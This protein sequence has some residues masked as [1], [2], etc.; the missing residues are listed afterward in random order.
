[1][2]VSRKVLFISHHEDVELGL[3]KKFFIDNEFKINILKPLQGSSLPLEIDDYI[4]V[5]ILG[6]AMD[7]GDSKEYPEIEKELYWIKNLLKKIFL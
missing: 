1:M 7:A 6:G 5:I 4:G 3:M 2:S